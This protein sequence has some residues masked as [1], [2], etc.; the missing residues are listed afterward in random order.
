[1][2]GLGQRRNLRVAKVHEDRKKL[3]QI[4]LRQAGTL[5]GPVITTFHGYDA[6]LLPRMHGPELYQLLFKRGDSR[7]VS[8]FGV[9][10]Y[11]FTAEKH[12]AKYAL[13]EHLRLIGEMRR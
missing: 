13:G 11:I 4:E 12:I 1:M 6:N 9:R 8:A 7:V 3:T 2:H 10:H 5:R